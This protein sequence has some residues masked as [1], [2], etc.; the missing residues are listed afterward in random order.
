MPLGFFYAFLFMLDAKLE[1]KLVE[2]DW[3]HFF[4]L[5]T[6]LTQSGIGSSE[7]CVMADLF[8][9]VKVS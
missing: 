8:S 1:F 7:R 6:I 5:F 3:R 2:N 4:P 9:A